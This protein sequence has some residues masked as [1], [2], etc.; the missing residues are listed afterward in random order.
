MLQTTFWDVTNNVSGNVFKTFLGVHK[1]S[2]FKHFLKTFFKPS[3]NVFK[4]FLKCHIVCWA[5]TYAPKTAPVL[6]EQL[7]LMDMIALHHLELLRITALTWIVNECNK[8]VADTLHVACQNK[9]ESTAQ[10][11]LNKGAGVN[12]INKDWV[13]PLFSNFMKWTREHSELL[14]AN[15]AHVK[16][17]KGDRAW[18]LYVACQEGH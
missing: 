15:G 14:L 3:S 7:A 16:F 13:F 8:D 12:S 11:L 4:T 2:F 18:P 5:W 17:C 6:F 1:F 10:L 9:H